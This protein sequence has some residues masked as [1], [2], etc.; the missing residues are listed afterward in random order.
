MTLTI[1]L[2]RDAGDTGKSFTV[3]YATS[4]GTASPGTDYTTGSGTVS[5][6]ASDNTQTLTVLVTDW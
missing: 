1:N 3:I 5:F 6:G 2:T 4:D